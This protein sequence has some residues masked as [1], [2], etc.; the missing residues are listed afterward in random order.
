MGRGCQGVVRVT[1]HSFFRESEQ[2]Q[3]GRILIGTYK[4][5][6][7]FY[8][9]LVI[10]YNFLPTNLNSWLGSVM[11]K[12]KLKEQKMGIGKSPFPVSRIY[13]FFLTFW[14]HCKYI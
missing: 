8:F 11:K 5:L 12:K 10:F 7:L 9:C 1:H 14:I 4:K 2:G 13:L 6:I 3:F